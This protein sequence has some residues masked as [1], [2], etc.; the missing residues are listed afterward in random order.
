M[1]TIRRSNPRCS[2]RDRQLT[3]SSHEETKVLRPN[4][5]SRVL[6]KR[7]LPEATAETANGHV[8][9]S[10]HHTGKRSSS[11]LIVT[12][13][14]NGG[15]PRRRRKK[16]PLNEYSKF[17]AYAQAR[18]RRHRE[19]GSKGTPGF[20]DQ[21]P[22][23]LWA[24]HDL[25]PENKREMPI[26]GY[27]DLMGYGLADVRFPRKKQTGE[28]RDYLEYAPVE[29]EP[30]F[31]ASAGPYW[32]ITGD[33]GP[34][35][36]LWAFENRPDPP[37]TQ[38]LRKIAQKPKPESGNN[39]DEML[40]PEP[41]VI[42]PF[43]LLEEEQGLKRGFEAVSSGD[44]TDSETESPAKK[45]RRQALTR[46]GSSIRTTGIP[47]AG[48]I[49][50]KSAERRREI[51]RWTDQNWRILEWSEY[52]EPVPSEVTADAYRCWKRLLASIPDGY[53]LD[54]V[55]DPRT[56][57]PTDDAGVRLEYL[58][59]LPD[60]IPPKCPPIV[61]Y[62]YRY[63]CSAVS[64]RDVIQRMGIP[65]GT[66][67]NREKTRDE[68]KRACNGLNMRQGRWRSMLGLPPRKESS[69]NKT[70]PRTTSLPKS[71]WTE[72]GVL[73]GE[74]FGPMEF[75]EPWGAEEWP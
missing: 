37:D 61:S 63:S 21:A 1:A 17:V 31:R 44:E 55:E 3:D 24:V 67:N 47:S 72:Y 35:I 38:P 65:I 13:T 40:K 18:L 50:L 39:I 36:P 20:L 19:K 34:A 29:F 30:F 11:K 57:V 74:P 27:D 26:E 66:T 43:A 69:R 25:R 52:W 64:M 5:H 68:C 9:S 56:S 2:V 58:P 75:D 70:A 7:H 33:T 45:I 71:E 41:Q 14:L 73:P 6:R 15:I 46:E 12:E 59:T 10:I 51:K 16:K 49:Y 62:A 22:A 53:Q 60:R 23:N 28:D 4:S 32:A 8:R 48:M 54:E 42:A